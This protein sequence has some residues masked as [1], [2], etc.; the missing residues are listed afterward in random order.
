MA[1]LHEDELCEMDECYEE[2]LTTTTLPLLQLTRTTREEAFS[3]FDAEKPKCYSGV[4]LSMLKFE[5]D[6]DSVHQILEFC[7][8]IHKSAGNDD[9]ESGVTLRIAY[10]DLGSGTDCEQR[11]FELKF[12]RSMREKEMAYWEKMKRDSAKEKD[13]AS[14]A[15]KRNAGQEGIAK[16]AGNLE[17]IDNELDQLDRPKRDTQWHILFNNM[18]LRNRN[19]IKSLD[20]RNCGLHATGIS[21]LTNVILGLEHRGDGEKVTEIVLD[22]NDLRDA[23]MGALSS[24][25]RLS[26]GLEA[27][28][29]RNVGI[30]DQGLS[31]I[32][33]GLVTNKTLLLL[34]LR[35]NGLCTPAVAQEVKAGMRRF[36]NITEILL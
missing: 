14:S 33:A 16:A 15:K 2:A 25:I 30:T 10:T 11:I 35:D 31:E 18:E 7:S 22:G 20:L 1:P 19:G 28:M 26:S 12:Q 36:N 3:Q 6:G 4:D 24:F 13:F 8:S 17:L 23:S 5:L 27:L 34:D 32:I 9:P 29:L 21:M